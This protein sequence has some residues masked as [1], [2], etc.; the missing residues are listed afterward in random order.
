M[1][2]SYGVIAAVGFLVAISIGLIAA[3]PDS[4]IEPRVL[5]EEKPQFKTF[6]MS[7]AISIPEGTGTPG[8]E[9][10]ESGE[11]AISPIEIATRTPTAAITP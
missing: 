3:S 8:C 11:A 10:T 9:I 6:P 2:F 1:N 5:P 4:V 7:L